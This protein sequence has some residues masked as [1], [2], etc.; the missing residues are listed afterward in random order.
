MIFILLHPNLIFN[1]DLIKISNVNYP[2]LNRYSHILAFQ[3]FSLIFIKMGKIFY[4]YKKK[5]VGIF[6][7]L[8]LYQL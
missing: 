8:G 7:I 5:T 2:L 6:P 1:I 4:Y 3:L